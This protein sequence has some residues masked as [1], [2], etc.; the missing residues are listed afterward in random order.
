MK[1]RHILGLPGSGEVEIVSFKIRDKI[2]ADLPAQQPGYVRGFPAAGWNW[3]SAV[4]DGT[5]PIEDICLWLEESYMAAKSKIAFYFGR[6][7]VSHE[8]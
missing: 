6:K 8:Y 5:I 7:R 2:L 3:T 4:L 1:D